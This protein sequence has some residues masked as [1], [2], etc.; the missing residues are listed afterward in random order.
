[1]RQMRLLSFRQEES[2]NIVEQLVQKIKLL[3]KKIKQFFKSRTIDAEHIIGYCYLMLYMLPFLVNGML[4]IVLG[5]ILNE[6]PFLSFLPPIII[7]F[8]NGI[9]LF[10]FTKRIVTYIKQKRFLLSLILIYIVLSFLIAFIFWIGTIFLNITV[11]FAMI[12][13]NSLSKNELFGLISKYSYGYQTMINSFEGYLRVVVPFI[14]ILGFSYFLNLFVPPKYQNIDIPINKK[15]IRIFIKVIYLIL[16]IVFFLIFLIFSIVDKDSYTVIA[17]IGLLII[18]FSK[19]KNII[20]L[21]DRSIIISDEDVKP[22]VINRIKILQ[23]FLTLIEIS[24]G[25]SVYFFANYSAAERLYITLGILSIGLILL[26]IWQKY[27]KAHKTQ[28]LENTLKKESVQK[29]LDHIQTDKT[30]GEDKQ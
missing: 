19:P 18:W 30:E 9:F 13:P 1:M 3:P 14:Q 28:W 12:N 11:M 10:Y 22:E 8:I 7:C 16:P 26:I 24:W 20:S 2:L 21:L 6:I 5:V 25:I 17:G 27:I 29:I 4:F 15:I 23:L